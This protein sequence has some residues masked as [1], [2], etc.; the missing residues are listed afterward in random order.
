MPLNL[1][2][3]D[4]VGESGD[5]PTPPFGHPSLEGILLVGGGRLLRFADADV[6]RNMEMVLGSIELWIDDNPLAKSPPLR[7]R[8]VPEG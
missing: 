7:S 6:E 2:H 4:V 3:A 1:K 5:L 8:S